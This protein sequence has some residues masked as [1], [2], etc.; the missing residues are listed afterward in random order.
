MR[1]LTDE[2]QKYPEPAQKSLI[3]YVRSDVGQHDWILWNIMA[4][5]SFI[6]I[7]ARRE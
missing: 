7:G 4:D 6:M 1:P 5:Q 3:L 2:K